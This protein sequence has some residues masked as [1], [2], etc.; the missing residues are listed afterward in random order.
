[1]AQNKIIRREWD[2]LMSQ[3]ADNALGF[4]YTDY[5]D[6]VRDSYG[7]ITGGV[8]KAV[9]Q[10]LMRGITI[11][12]P[13][14]IQHYSGDAQIFNYIDQAVV[15]KVSATDLYNIGVID[16]R[17]NYEYAD[18]DSTGVVEGILNHKF[19]MWKGEW[20]KITGVRK[21][22][23]YQGETSAIYFT[24]TKD[25]DYTE[26]YGKSTLEVI[27]TPISDTYP[28]YVDNVLYGNYV[29]GA[30]VN[31]EVPVREGFN[32]DGF[33][34]TD[35]VISANSF[36][37]PSKQVN[38]TTEWTQV[39]FN[40]KVTVDNV[41]I[42]EY[43][44]GDT[45]EI[46]TAER[47]GFD[48]DGWTSEPQVEFSDSTV[49]STT[50]TMVNSDVVITSHWTEVKEY[51]TVVVNNTGSGTKGTYQVEKGQSLNLTSG[52]KS[53]YDFNG[54]T[55][56]TGTGTF[57][58][59]TSSS[60]TFTPTSNATITCVW[61]SQFNYVTV[62]KRDGSILSHSLK[63][64]GSNVQFTAPAESGYDFDHWDAQGIDLTP[65]QKTQSYL[66]FV[67]P[68]NEV[69]LTTNY[70]IKEF[71]VTFMVDDTTY[72][73]QTVAYG[74]F[75]TKPSVDPTKEHYTFSHWSKNGVE[76][77]FSTAITS[78]T[79]LTASFNRNTVTVTWDSDGGSEVSPTTVNEGDTLGSSITT[80]PTSTKSGFVLTGWSVGGVEIDLSYVVSEDV[81]AVAQ[82]EEQSTDT[83]EAS[84][85][86]KTARVDLEVFNASI[87]KTKKNQYQNPK[88][89]SERGNNGW[90]KIPMYKS[91]LGDVP[92]GYT[93]DFPACPISNSHVYLGDYPNSG[94]PALKVSDD[95]NPVTH[96]VTYSK[97]H[98]TGSKRSYDNR[99]TQ[100]GI[101]T[102]CCWENV[103]YDCGYSSSSTTFWGLASFAKEPTSGEV[104]ALALV[105]QLFNDDGTANGWYRYEWILIPP[106]EYTWNTL[107]V[108]PNPTTYTFEYP[109]DPT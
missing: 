27:D 41:V 28:V 79:T 62:Y 21:A 107:N 19:I 8:T 36:T 106:I 43:K 72:D 78:D 57:G 64:K 95:P 89:T 80:M 39:V 71:T 51:W 90:T 104:M 38:I 83:G 73:S 33:S 67:M 26:W 60:T 97:H 15:F 50:F 52:E 47:E 93:T 2:Y 85:I 25:I 34:S 12:D 9:R 87:C 53:G 4:Y 5:S 86:D 61:L 42:G 63:K 76:F 29:E 1:M 48:F 108:D 11:T 69:I 66:S 24:T 37:M 17:N 23:V 59:E 49:R 44:A 65:A 22:L 54:W 55:R 40:F 100:Q 31:L 84:T 46:S 7:Q 56:D 94:Y 32:F 99:I 14:V 30:V 102:L 6:A 77:N 88:M 10:G 96:L 98:F 13:L 18:I 70:T 3:F 68:Q 103:N 16:N 75:A 92:S 105:T 81:T 58:D 45:V 109:I 101:P 91:S 82:W 20:Y 74:G 35:V